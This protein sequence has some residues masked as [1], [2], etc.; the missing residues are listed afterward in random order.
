MELASQVT[1]IAPKAGNHCFQGVADTFQACQS[2][3]DHYSLGQDG[4]EGPSGRG[5]ATAVEWVVL[6]HASLH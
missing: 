4:E 3:P 2:T 5:G 1:L 6:V